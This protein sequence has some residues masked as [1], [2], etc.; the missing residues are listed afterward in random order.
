VTKEA[1]LVMKK[2]II[3][4]WILGSVLAVSELLPPAGSKPDAGYW[5]FL[6]GSIVSYSL[7]FCV[8]MIIRIPEIRS[9]Q[10]YIVLTLFALV[11]AIN[12]FIPVRR[13]LPGYHPKAL[14]GLAYLFLP[15]VELGLIGL[16]IVVAAATTF[17]LGKSAKV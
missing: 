7:P 11:L 2:Y 9:P 15:P 12:L 16:F 5:G 10:R 4:L 6:C 17:L 1:G 3:P 13:F 8:L 14:E